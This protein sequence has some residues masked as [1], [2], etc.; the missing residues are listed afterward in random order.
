MSED[1]L[2]NRLHYNDFNIYLPFSKQ[3]IYLGTFMT[4]LKCSFLLLLYF[5]KYILLYSQTCSNA[6]L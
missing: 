2:T 1:I 4:T 6:K 5:R 3:H